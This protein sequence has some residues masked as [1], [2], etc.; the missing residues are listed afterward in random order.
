[1]FTNTQA[2]LKG[3]VAMLLRTPSTG[4]LLSIISFD[5]PKN[6]VENLPSTYFTDEETKAVHD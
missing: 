4:H 1:L 2:K 3:I 6:F 5:P